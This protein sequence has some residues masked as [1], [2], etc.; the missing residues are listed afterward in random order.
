M[1]FSYKKYDA[2]VQD[3]TIR[4]F[5]I[6]KLIAHSSRDDTEC[7]L[8]SNY[9]LNRIDLARMHSIPC[10]HSALFNPTIYMNHVRCIFSLISMLRFSFS[11]FSNSSS[12]IRSHF[13]R[14]HLNMLALF[15]KNVS[16]EKRE[17]Y[18]YEISQCNKT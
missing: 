5:C 4:S 13:L 15:Q 10:T 8:T 6:E 16:C 12:Q 1:Q 14:L 18:L 11:F 2:F 9:I 7:Y 3:T 17:Y